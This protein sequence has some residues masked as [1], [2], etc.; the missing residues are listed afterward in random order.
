MES[1]HQ[2]GHHTFVVFLLLFVLNIFYCA[3]GAAP[4]HGFAT[5]DGTPDICFTLF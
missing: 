5:P 1:Q 3:L 2:T 4:Q